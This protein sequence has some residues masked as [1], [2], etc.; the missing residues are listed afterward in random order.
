MKSPRCGPRGRGPA[1]VGGDV[2]GA[3]WALPQDGNDFG[4]ALAVVLAQLLKPAVEVGEP[5]LV[6]RQDLVDPVGLEL[7]ERLEEVAGGFA[8]AWGW[9][10]MF[11]VMRGRTSSPESISSLRDS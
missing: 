6:R 10:G 2:P 11:G 1:D 8:P 7:V 9:K 3:V 5:V 4:E